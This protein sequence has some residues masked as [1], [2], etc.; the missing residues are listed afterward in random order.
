MMTAFFSAWRLWWLIHKDLTREIRAPQAWPRTMLLGIVLVLL[1]ATQIDLPMGQQTRVISGLLWTTIFFS[2]TLAIE[3]SFPSEHDDGCWQALL[4]FPV[5][6]SMIFFA[7]MIVNVASIVI[8]EALLIPLFIVLTDVPLLAR[9]GPLVLIAVLGS[10][11]F[12]AVGTLL[13]GIT[14]GM[15]NQGGLLALLLLPLVAPVLLSS[16]EATRIAL[17][18]VDDPLWW[19]WIQLLAAFAAVFTAVGALAFGFVMED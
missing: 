7:K 16:A 13:G 11:G 15:R 4:L 6:P 8:L 17:A 5:A 3:R 12:A 10:I 2:G 18:S 9:P 19:W 1:L 14:A